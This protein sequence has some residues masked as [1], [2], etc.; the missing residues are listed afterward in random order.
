[1][2][3]RSQVQLQDATG[4]AAAY[5]TLPMVM[6]GPIRPDVVQDV[7]TRMSKN[8][9]QPYAVSKYAGMQVSAESWGT[10]RAVARLPRVHGSG[11]HRAG[12]GAF[13]NMARGGRMFGPTKVWRKWH[14]KISTNQR[15]YAT[16]SAL[17]ASAVPALVQARGHRIENVPEVPLVLSTASTSG[18]AKT[19]QAAELLRAVGAYT[20]VERVAAS[21]QI[22]T[23][24]GKGRNRRYTQRRGPLLVYKEDSSLTKAM[25]NLP[26]VEVCQ[27]SRLNLLQLAPGGHL[28]RFVIWTQ[29][30]F[31]DL[32]TLYGN[33]RPNSSSK[34]GFQL[35]RPA[36]TNTDLT[37]I[38]NSEEIQSVLRDKHTS[39]QKPSRK[40]NPLK[41]LGFLIKLNP[42][43]KAQRRSTIR[44]QQQAAERKDAATRAVRAKKVASKR[45]TIKARNAAANKATLAL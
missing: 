6:T 2:A 17:A 5:V 20:D 42:Y 28:G 12:Q 45:A 41:N 19:K 29:D 21:H 34:A 26:G 9:R 15:R 10:G 32:H 8:R 1:M 27:V 33:N 35:P 13:A 24:K 18:I 39:R 11:T 37:R 22:R 44:A 40:R 36:M 7:F 3:A 25:R 30:A 16:V 43:A 23:G 31:A 14:A 4:P 38:I